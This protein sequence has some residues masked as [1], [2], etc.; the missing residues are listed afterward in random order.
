M[1]EVDQP[2]QNLGVRVGQHAVP[3]VEH[4]A[5]PTG[6]AL[7]NVDGTRFGRLPAGQ[8]PD[9]IEV[10]LDA[11]VEP[12]ALPALVEPYPPVE[13]EEVAA[14]LGHELE[15]GRISRPEVD[16]RRQAAEGAEDT[17]APREH[18]AFEVG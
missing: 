3:Q 14:S 1:N 18:A 12:A 15:Q 7:Q 6:R 16:G 9:R 17:L 13:A 5:G 2:T 11:A 10:A 8:R 4:M